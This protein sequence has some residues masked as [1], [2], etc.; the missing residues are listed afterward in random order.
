ME[1]Y[2]QGEC[3]HRRHHLL[4]PSFA[5][6]LRHKLQVIP[7]ND[8]ECNAKRHVRHACH[9]SQCCPRPLPSLAQSR[10]RN[11]RE[12]ASPS[13]T[14]HAGAP[15][16][17][18]LS[19]G[20][21]VNVMPKPFF[22]PTWA[23]SPSTNAA[24]RSATSMLCRA[25]SAPFS[26]PATASSAFDHVLGSGISDKGKILTQLSLFWFDFPSNPSFLTTSSLRTRR[27]FPRSSRLI[28]SQLDGRSMLV[29]RAKMFPV[30]CVVRGYLSGSGWTGLPADQRDLAASNCPP[31][32]VN[33][34]A[35]PNRSLHPS[36]QDQHRRP[37]RKTS[38]TTR[39]VIQTIG[40]AHANSLRDLTMAIYDKAAKHAAS[41]GLI[42]ADTKFE[43]GLLGDRIILAD[44]VLTPDS[45]RYWPVGNLQSRRSSALLRQT[46]RP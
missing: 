9:Q 28:S 8:G 19:G 2:R 35:S 15:F 44:E 37:R 10:L 24:G 3:G 18:D 30:E 1:Q 46:V 45:S 26:S 25:I 7:Y 23:H 20:G 27:N 22:K 40:A 32:S 16:N 21:T 5:P 43:F 33:P 6:F 14:A 29:E 12:T 42:L 34:T 31:A 17:S 38:L 39:L 36:G 4:H 13:L 11:R 41:K